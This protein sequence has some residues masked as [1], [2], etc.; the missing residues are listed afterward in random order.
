MPF[1]KLE[2]I[3]YRRASGGRPSMQLKMFSNWV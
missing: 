2:M 3:Q 1:L